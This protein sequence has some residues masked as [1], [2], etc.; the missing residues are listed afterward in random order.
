VDVQDVQDN[1]IAVQDPSQE[2]D[3]VLTRSSK[4]VYLMATVTVATDC[5]SD[6]DEHDGRSPVYKTYSSAHGVK[7]SMLSD[8]DIAVIYPILRPRV[9]SLRQL[10]HWQNKACV[11]KRLCSLVNAS[12]F[13][14]QDMAAAM[15][16]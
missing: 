10:L 5:R 1:E 16:K 13:T 2:A 4:P 14:F 9:A 12:R 6:E 15:V 11:L 7:Q 3:E 8:D